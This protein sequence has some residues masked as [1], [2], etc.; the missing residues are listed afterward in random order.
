MSHALANMPQPKHAS[1]SSIKNINYHIKVGEMF[2]FNHVSPECVHYYIS[3]LKVKKS[4]G[5]DGLS[6]LFVKLSGPSICFSLSNIFN[7]CI[8]NCIFLTSMKLAEISP[9]FKTKNNL[10]KE[11]Y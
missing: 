4:V 5:H 1:H 8:S 11:N 7:R 2:S 3:K 6:A 10:F 9:I